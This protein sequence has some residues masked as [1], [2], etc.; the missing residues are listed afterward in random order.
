MIILTSVEQQIKAMLKDQSSAVGKSNDLSPSNSIFIYE[1]T[2]GE[3]QSEIMTLKP[4]ISFSPDR[5]LL[6]NSKSSI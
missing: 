1:T 5:N 6:K 3:V 4:K 2:A